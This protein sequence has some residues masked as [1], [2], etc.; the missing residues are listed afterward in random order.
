M[1]GPGV[2]EAPRVEAVTVA[3][4][5]S[6][7]VLRVSARETL[8][9]PGNIYA[10]K[11]VEE[12]AERRWQWS[13]AGHPGPDYSPFECRKGDGRSDTAVLWCELDVDGKIVRSVPQLINVKHYNPG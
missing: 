11:P 7:E 13:W 9:S 3:P 6:Y 1:G 12:F 4:G 8:I 5:D 2:T 10:E